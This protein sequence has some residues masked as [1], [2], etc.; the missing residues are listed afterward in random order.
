MVNDVNLLAVGESQYS[1]LF[2]VEGIPL[3][4]LLVYRMGEEH[5]LVV[6]NASN[7]DK[8]WA[9]VNAVLKGEVMIDAGR[10]WVKWPVQDGV[11]LRDLRDPSAGAAM[12]AEL[13]L[14]G[15]KSRDI[16][17]ALGGEAGDLTKI[18]NLPWAGITR[19]TL[20]GFDVIVSR[21]GYTGERVAYELFVHPDRLAAFWKA[22]LAVGEP[23]GIKPCGLAARDSLRTEA[24]L[25]LYGH[26]MAGPL[27]LTMADAGFGTYIKTYKPFF[28]GREAFIAREARRKAEVI[29][30]QVPE[31]G[32][33]KPERLDRL[34]DSKGK[35]VGYVTS[36]SVDT[37]GYLLGQ[38][39]VNENDQAVGAALS[40]LVTP[41]RAPKP[42][43]QLKMGE[44][45]QL[46]VPVIVLSRFPKRK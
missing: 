14:Q 13:A 34:V 9:W 38:A 10:P 7:N 44:R 39:Y 45:T 30:F 6:V 17:L 42:Q 1:A 35:V 4:D 37:E 19:V 16:L 20:G 26:E 23:M 27:N 29:R 18:K 5:Y 21:T 43:D 33:P 32:Q 46:P 8:D 31:K 24:G 11:V 2:D 3:D 22:L 36:C 40:V 12:R 15:P 25:P 41:R 28:V